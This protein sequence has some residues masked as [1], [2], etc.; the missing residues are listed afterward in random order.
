MVLDINLFLNALQ[1]GINLDQRS[2][3]EALIT[4]QT[5]AKPE[6]ACPETGGPL[7]VPAL[8]VEAIPAVTVLEFCSIAIKA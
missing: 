4:C 5:V 8:R 6:L 2:P 7:R 1:E 3:A